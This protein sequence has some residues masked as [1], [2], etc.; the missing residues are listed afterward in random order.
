MDETG[1]ID[2]SLILILLGIIGMLFLAVA[3]I[4]FFI[5][6]Q[7]RAF[8][9]QERIKDI[10]NAYQ[11]D[12]LTSSIEAQEKERKRVAGELHDGL[13][14]MLSAIRL[15]V[16]NL[17][18]DQSPSTYQELLQETKSMVDTAINQTR[19]ISHNLMPAILDRFGFVEALESHCQQLQRLD[20]LTVQ[21]D[22]DS[23]IVFTK[24]QDL[25]LYRICQ[26]LINN[27]IKHAK[28]TKLM[29][30]LRSTQDT[31]SVSYRDNGIGM[32]PEQLSKLRSGLGLKSIEGRVSLLNGKMQIDSE[33]GNGFAFELQAPLARKM[34]KT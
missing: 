4:V 28:A 14:S 20:G 11:K 21:F 9:Q 8:A 1:S 25:A 29:I 17:S 10:E 12:L 16:L 6:Y 15:Y 30:K 3:V 23:E 32:A 33:K 5:V 2:S 27:S 34:E 31:F 22:Y 18:P 24:Q 13:G 19:E 7:K 26:E